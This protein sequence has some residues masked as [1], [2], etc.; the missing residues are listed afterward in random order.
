M[1]TATGKYHPVAG[2][3]TGLIGGLNFHKNSRDLGFVLTA[4]G[5]LPMFIPLT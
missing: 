1:N 5:P 2:I 3:P 4:P